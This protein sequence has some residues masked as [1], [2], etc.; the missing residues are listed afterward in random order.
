[1]DD[2]LASTL[3]AAI[4]LDIMA[5]RQQGGPDDWHVEEAR[6]RLQAIR[7]SNQSE[8]IFFSM[9]GTAKAFETYAECIAVLAFM[10]GGVKIADRRFVASCEDC[11][12][13]EDRA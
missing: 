1:M 10:P 6:R 9:P 5:L 3:E 11:E 8:A 2:L 13:T 12:N 7:E 4:M